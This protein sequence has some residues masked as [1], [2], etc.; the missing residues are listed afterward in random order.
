MAAALLIGILSICSLLLYTYLTLTRPLALILPKLKLTRKQ[1]ISL[2]ITNLTF[3]ARVAALADGIEIQD[4][5]G[6]TNSS[7]PNAFLSA[8]QMG[9]SILP[10][11]T[12]KGR[13]GTIRI[14]SHCVSL[15]MSKDGKGDIFTGEESTGGS[16]VA[17][18]QSHHPH[19]RIDFL[20][21]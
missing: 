2:D 9:I 18:Y 20:S 8:R 3:W 6:F 14:Q 12:A 13:L 16:S 19:R 4:R 15:N 10:L 21:G 5:S 7:D 17:P 1:N 11:L